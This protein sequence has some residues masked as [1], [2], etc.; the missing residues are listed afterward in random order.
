MGPAKSRIGMGRH[1]RC[2]STGSRRS[3]VVATKKTVPRLREVGSP[4]PA[5]WTVTGGDRREFVLVSAPAG[6]GKSTLLADWV[7]LDR[8]LVAWLSF[9]EGD[10]D[11]VRFWRHVAA[12]G[13][14]SARSGRP[15]LL[16]V[17]RRRRRSFLG[18]GAGQ[19]PG[20]A[21]EDV[22]LVVDEYHLIHAPHVHRSVEFLLDTCRLAPARGGEPQRPAAAVRETPRAGQS[23][24]LRAADL[25]FTLAEAA[26]LIAASTGRIFPQSRRGAGGAHRERA[27]GL[28]LTALSLQGRPDV[29]A[30]SRSLRQPR[31]VLDYLTEEVL[32]RQPPEV[33]TFLLETSVPDRLSGRFGCGARESG[34]PRSWNPSSAR[35]CS[36]SRSTANAG[37]GA[38][39]TC[40]RICCGPGCP[41]RTPTGRACTGR[42]RLLRAAGAARRRDPTR[43]GRG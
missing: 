10:N 29:R 27:A 17:T 25:R 8:R 31:F 24:E 20:R 12:P 28:P 16:S 4:A 38:T 14:D 37:G 43:A 32:D 36:C 18:H 33:R 41:A 23:A 35:T 2:S 13:P 42:R 7:R 39:T 11:P 5:S 9:D 30:P 6:F 21:A 15:I 40:S 26:Q 19:R 34:Q 22:V 3:P 1:G